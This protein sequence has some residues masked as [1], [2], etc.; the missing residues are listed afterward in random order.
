MRRTATP[1]AVT[2]P[3]TLAA[4]IAAIA[5]AL[6]VERPGKSKSTRGRVEADV[7]ASSAA[8]PAAAPSGPSA[9]SPQVRLGFHVGDQWEPAIAAD[10]HGSIYVLYPQYGGVPEMPGR[11]VRQPDRHPAGESRSRARPGTRRGRSRP[12]AR[13]RWT[14]RSSWTGWTGARC[15]HPGCRTGRATRS[16]AR[17]NDLGH[18]WSVVVADSTNAGTDKPILAVR[19][20]RHLRGLQPCAEGV[21]LVVARRGCDLHVRDRQPQRQARM[22]PGRRRLGHTGRRRLLRVGGLRAERRCQGAREPVREQ[23]HRWRRHLDEPGRGH[24]GRA[25][26]LLGVPLRLGVPRRADHS[27]LAT[28]RGR[29]TPCGTPAAWKRDRSASTS[30]ARRTEAPRGRR[31]W[32]SRRAT[33]GAA[34]AFPAIAAGAPGDVRISWMDARQAPLWNVYHR[35]SSDGGRQ[36]IGREGPLHLHRRL[37]LYRGLR[38]SAIPFGDYYEIDIDDRGASQL[39]WGEGFNW[40]TRR[41]RS[42]TPADG[43]L[44]CHRTAAES[45]RR[46]LDQGIVRCFGARPPLPPPPSGSRIAR[47]WRGGSHRPRIVPSRLRLQVLV[48]VVRKV[49]KFVDF[50]EIAHDDS[51]WSARPSARRPAGRRRPRPRDS[52]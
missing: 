2:L 19:G 46:T 12:R 26:G 3:L 27:G 37:Q 20:S 52:A 32:T 6:I 41:G 49:R 22:V 16:V 24:V 43:D 33:A 29:S 31:R 17:S 15:T 14:P 21:G 48:V 11:R 44:A 30:P 39:I 51:G 34:H 45:P 28:R 36:F 40:Q 50:G 10:D 38:A 5:P 25:P 1:T 47:G 8:Q 18:T 4:A 9:F 35:R 13:S 7:V 42:G 23:E